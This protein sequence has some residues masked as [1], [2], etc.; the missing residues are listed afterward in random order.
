[1]QDKNYIET[2]TLRTCDCDMRGAWRPSAILEAMQET[3]IAHCDKLNLGRNVTDSL[4][5][6]WVLSRSR[7]ALERLPHIGEAVSVETYPLPLKHLFYPRM[8][9]FRG[10]DGE[11]IGHA[12]SL[13][14][15]ID[16]STRRIVSNETIVSR[17]PDNS[18]LAAP[19][20]GPA[21]V[22]ALPGEAEAHEVAPRFTDFDI[23]G[24]VNN[25]KYL[26]WCLNALGLETMRAWELRQF[27]VNYEAEILPDAAVVRTELTRAGERFACL[28][29]ADG[30]RSF[31]VGGTLSPR[32]P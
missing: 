2:F 26:D 17:L 15:L 14:V 22:R 20:P 31:A 3:A 24:H 13:W 12:H 8:N 4:G 1:M 18:D 32:E 7:V 25:T 11:V 29:S 6:A 5:V 9:T 30:K 28:G 21:T 16:L 19:I 23:N 27:D 10:A